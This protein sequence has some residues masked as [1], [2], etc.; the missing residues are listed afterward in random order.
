MTMTPPARRLAPSVYTEQRRKKTAR[1]YVSQCKMCTHS[2]FEDE[3]RTWQDKPM[4]LSH[5][6]CV[7]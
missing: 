4:G 6:W 2:I 1:K 5:D 7:E 3:P